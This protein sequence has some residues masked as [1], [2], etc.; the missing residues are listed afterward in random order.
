MGN[1]RT[2]CDAWKKEAAL[3]NKRAEL[4]NKD[5]EVAIVKCGSLQKEVSHGSDSTQQ[6][7]TFYFI[8]D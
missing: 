5:K 6:A 3:A 4:A 1:A 8:S 2:A 7:L